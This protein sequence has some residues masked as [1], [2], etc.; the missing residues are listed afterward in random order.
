MAD[1]KMTPEEAKKNALQSKATDPEEEKIENKRLALKT[2][3]PDDY[4]TAAARQAL[5]RLNKK[6]STKE[7]TAEDTHKKYET[8]TKAKPFVYK[9]GGMVKK[10]GMALVHTGEK[11]LTKN[12]QKSGNSKR[13]ACKR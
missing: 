8:E 4:K 2:P 13:I 11:V 7:D 10:G 3:S 1:K 5:Y 9:K 12:Q 6:E